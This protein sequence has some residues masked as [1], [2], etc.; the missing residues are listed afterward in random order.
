MRMPRRGS[1]AAEAAPRQR[2][3]VPRHILCSQAL[4]EAFAYE[5]GGIRKRGETNRGISGIIF[6]IAVGYYEGDDKMDRENFSWRRM[7]RCF[8]AVGLACAGYLVISGLC[9]LAAAKGLVAVGVEY[10]SRLWMF[11]TMVS[12]YP[13]STPV[14]YALM[15]RTPK[16]VQTWKKSLSVGQFIGIFIISTGFMYIGNLIGQFLMTIVSVMI[17]RPIMNNVQEMIMK[18]DMWTVLIVAVIIGPI[19]EELVFRK[20]L[21][22]RIAGYGQI[23]AMTVSGLIFGLAHGNFFQFFYAFALGMIFAW[24]YLRTGNILYTIG[25]HIMINFC[26]SIVPMT[27]MRIMALNPLLGSSL[28]MGQTMFMFASMIA[29]VVL[30]ICYRREIIMKADRRWIPKG[31]WTAAVFL[32]VGMIVFYVAAGVMFF[33]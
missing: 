5:E 2:E 30:L 8:S 11:V 1:L 32:N 29:A 12:M 20:F 21:L 24:V 16:A 27:L 17:G 14:C 25:L 3:N 26:G 19:M 23:T 33:I 18:M 22:D 15:R 7:R 4:E 10:E 28:T 6:A 9:Q 31:R 13:I